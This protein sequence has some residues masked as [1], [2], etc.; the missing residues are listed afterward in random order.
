MFSW[1]HIVWLLICAVAIIICVYLYNKNRPS[2][3]T[4][5]NYCCAVCVASELIKVFS[6]IDMVPSADGSL[7]Y[8]YIPMNHLPLHLCSMQILMIFYVR[9]TENKKSRENFLSFMYPSCLLGALSALAM[10]SIFT[11]S[12]RVDQAFT[13]P[14]AYQF[15]MFHSMLIVLAIAIAKSG[16]ISFTWK[17]YRNALIIIAVAGFVSLY[18]NSIF[19]SPYYENGKLM[20]IDF[21][22]NFLFTYQNPIGIKLTELWQWHVYLIILVAVTVVLTFICFYPLIRKNSKNKA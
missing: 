16:E 9:F 17:S 11:T 20:H 13:H 1:Q 12:I 6:V 4:V 22:P 14:M 8:P 15:F 21:W 2:L 19:A 7:I 3:Q 5:L 18:V 10:P